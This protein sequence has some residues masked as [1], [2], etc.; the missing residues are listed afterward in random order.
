MGRTTTLLGMMTA[1]REITKAMDRRR[2]G[3]TNEAHKVRVATGTRNRAFP[4]TRILPPER[5]RAIPA[6]KMFGEKIVLSLL[7]KAIGSMESGSGVAHA[8]LLNQLLM[9][10]TY[11]SPDSFITEEALQPL[12]KEY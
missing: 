9:G 12:R 10:V 6:M 5:E 8:G 4:M 7:D 3:E 2:E 1:M 11:F